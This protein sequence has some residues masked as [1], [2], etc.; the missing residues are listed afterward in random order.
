MGQFRKN[1]YIPEWFQNRFLPSDAREKKFYYLDLNPDA[2]VVNGRRHKRRELLRWGPP[3]CFCE[4]DLYTTRFG[5]WESTEIEERFFGKVDS[6]GRSAVEYFTTF[7]HPSINREA[8]Q[9]LLPY[10][11]I[12]KLRTPKGLNYLG[13]LVKLADKNQVL[14]KMQELQ[15]IFCSI[16]TESVWAIVDASESD[17]KFILSDHPATVYNHA[18]PLASKWCRGD[19]DPPIWL[20]GTHTLF[21]LSLNKMLMLTNLS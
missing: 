8:F 3:K 5:S 17:T 11:S 12:Q 14:F 2:R 18:C 7:E 13:G 19:N 1:H 20:S 4:E 15:N 16:W 6:S 10:M 21:P 9:T